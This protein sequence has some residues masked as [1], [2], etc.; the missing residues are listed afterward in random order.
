ML[1]H[2]DRRSDPW[3]RRRR[4]RV[5]RVDRLAPVDKLDEAMSRARWRNAG[6]LSSGASNI[7]QIIGLILFLLT[8]GAAIVSVT[9][10]IAAQEERAKDR[11]HGIELRIHDLELRERYIHGSY[12]L[13]KE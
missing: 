5:I 10:A 4:H 2:E 7:K 8:F 3:L 12:A 6:A 11:E 1:R 9:L 13:P